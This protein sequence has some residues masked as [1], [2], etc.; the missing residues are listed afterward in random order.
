MHEVD[1]E[2]IE[3][4]EDLKTAKAAFLSQGHDTYVD[5]TDNETVHAKMGM[6][7]IQ[8]GFHYEDGEWKIWHMTIYHC[9]NQNMVKDG[10]T[11]RRMY[12]K[13][14]PFQMPDLKKPIG[15]MTEMNCILP[16]SGHS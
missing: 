8:C 14:L 11:I 13:H 1:T 6:G 7:K 16:M 3:V 12:P 2:V 4:A 9:S 5:R 10:Q 15:I